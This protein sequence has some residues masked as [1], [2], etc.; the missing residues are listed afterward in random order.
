MKQTPPHIAI[1]P[2]PA[3][4]HLIPV[5]ELAR[6]LLL[7]DDLH[8]TII[9]PCSDDLPPSDA[10]KSVL[11]SL[12]KPN[13][14]TIFLP[15]DR[16]DDLPSD[17]RP[18]AELA[19]T[20]SHHLPSIHRVLKSL[21]SRNTTTPPLVAVFVSLFAI[22]ALDI[23]KGL[24]ISSYVFY[25]MNAISLSVFFHLSKLDEIA[26]SYDFL[27]DLPEPVK[28]PGCPSFRGRD[29]FSGVQ[30]RRTDMYKKFL[31]FSKR[32]VS[33]EDFKG[34]VVNSVRDIESE[35]V[36]A[37]QEENSGKLTIYPVGPIVNID[38]SGQN[39]QDSECLTWLGNQPRGSVLY[40]SFGSGG[41]LS[42]DQ[43]TELAFGLERSGQR[44]IWVVRKP[45]TQPPNATC[46]GPLEPLGFLPNGFLERTKGRGLVLPDWAPQVR[47]LGHGSTGG[48]LSHCGWSST[49]ESVVN[50]VP[51]IVWPLA[52]EQKMNAVL[53]VE[54]LKVALRPKADDEDGLVRREEI[55]NLVKALMEGTSEECRTVRN[56][57]KDLKDLAVKAL[58]EDGSSTRALS[59]LVSMLKKI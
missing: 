35:A 31:Q 54:R 58:G 23:A 18:T 10:T 46:L 9:I 47:V 19:F 8:V 52:A 34:I 55:A 5:V 24:G 28:L 13:T 11:E 21:A 22:D 42:F 3:I 4:S 27:K 15:P 33:G 49:L 14:R 36:K 25:P 30:D 6:R 53:L 17:S 40:V 56:R 59:Q 37:L 51:L 39:N 16:F 12:P 2:S 57:M 44:F 48:F 50:G 26:A 43:M 32:L 38:S 20:V 7:H 45:N 29:L 1:L 41:T